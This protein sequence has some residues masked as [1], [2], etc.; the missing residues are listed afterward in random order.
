MSGQSKRRKGH[1]MF[2][3]I[4]V[5]DYMIIKGVIKNLHDLKPEHIKKHKNK[6]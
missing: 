5:E 6:I 3:T 4:K 1:G 2:S